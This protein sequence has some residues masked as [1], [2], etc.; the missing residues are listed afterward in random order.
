[1]LIGSIIQERDKKNAEYYVGDYYKSFPKGDSYSN[2]R[3]SKT[4]ATQ[5][6]ELV[7]NGSNIHV[8]FYS[9]LLYRLIV[10]V[11][12]TLCTTEN[13]VFPILLPFP[14]FYGTY[15]VKMKLTREIPNFIPV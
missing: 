12:V 9:I 3:I 6:S 4:E 7:K 5:G 15:Q 11:R 1:M 8:L 10:Y 14:L 13:D 2:G